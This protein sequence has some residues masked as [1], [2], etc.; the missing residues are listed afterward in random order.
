MCGRYVHPDDAAMERAWHVGRDN[1]NPFAR[2]F[3]VLPTSIVPLLRRDPE[4]GKLALAGA[5]WGLIPHWWK[6]AMLPKFTINARAEEAAGK[7]MWRH[8][9]RHARCLIPAEGWYEWR[10][11][12]RVSR[13]TGE[14]KKYKQP[15]YIH[16]SDEHPFCFAGLMALWQKSGSDDMT[17]SC[18]IITKPAAGPAT[19]VHDRM[20]VVLPEQAFEEWSDP[21]LTD[22]ARVQSIIAECAQSD[23][24]FH[25]VS[26]KVNSSRNAG[27]D[28]IEPAEVA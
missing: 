21:A 22:A 1:S 25:A 9:W 23:F 13:E 28:L 3:N 11:L 7:P 24:A 8:A 19:E 17:L 15:Y 14:V 4:S 5:R 10:E 16:R 2:Q 27:P 12:E 26:T 6:D 18:A 20:P